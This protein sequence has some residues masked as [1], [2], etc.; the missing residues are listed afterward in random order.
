MKTKIVYL[1]VDHIPVNGLTKLFFF[2]EKDGEIFWGTDNNTI[3]IKDIE[4][5]V[6]EKKIFKLI[7]PIFIKEDEM[8]QIGYEGR[9]YISN[10]LIEKLVLVGKLYE[11][12]TL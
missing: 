8:L 1:Q 2:T 9:V 10:P 5:W 12:T 11:L 6:K 3:E 7:R 4:R